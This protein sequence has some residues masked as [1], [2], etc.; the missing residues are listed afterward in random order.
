MGTLTWRRHH[1]SDLAAQVVQQRESYVA[2]VSHEPSGAVCRAP[3]TFANPQAAK[4]AADEL[5]RRS[6]GHQCTFDRCGQWML[7]PDNTD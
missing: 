5:V 3:K 6:F 4:A 7:W 2:E 1:G